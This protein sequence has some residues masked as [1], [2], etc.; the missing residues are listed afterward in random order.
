MTVLTLTTDFG[1]TKVLPAPSMTLNLPDKRRRG[2][3][4]ERVWQKIWAEY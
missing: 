3:R 2:R 1:R 4:R